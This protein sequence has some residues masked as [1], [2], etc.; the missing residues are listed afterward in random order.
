MDRRTSPNNENQ[1]LANK[2]ATAIINNK[3]NAIYN[4]AGADLYGLSD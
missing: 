2:S 1:T 4:S 3:Y